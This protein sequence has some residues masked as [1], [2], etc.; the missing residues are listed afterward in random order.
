MKEAA[1]SDWTSLRG[2]GYVNDRP[3][4]E[5]GGSSLAI[6]ITIILFSVLDFRTKTNKSYMITASRFSLTHFACLF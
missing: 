6:I 3:R 2:N 4:N 5:L 1:I